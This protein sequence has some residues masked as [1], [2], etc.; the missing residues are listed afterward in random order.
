MEKYKREYT[1]KCYD[2]VTKNNIIEQTYTETYFNIDPNDYE[3]LKDVRNWLQQVV[4]SDDF[5]NY[6]EDEQ[7]LFYNLDQDIVDILGHIKK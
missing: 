2:P 4:E 1:Y 3:R 7:Y 6:T 5:E